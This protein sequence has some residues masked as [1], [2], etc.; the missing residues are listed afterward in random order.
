[1]TPETTIRKTTML[2]TDGNLGITIDTNEKI[3]L[4]RVIIE[5]KGKLTAKSKRIDTFT[6]PITAQQIRV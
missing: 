6:L 3:G 4:D 5:K 2:I 1:M